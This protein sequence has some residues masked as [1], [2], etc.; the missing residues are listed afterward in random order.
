MKNAARVFVTS[1]L[2]T[3]AISCGDIGIAPQLGEMSGELVTPVVKEPYDWGTADFIVALKD[4]PETV[5]F[6]DDEMDPAYKNKDKMSAFPIRGIGYN[7][8]A[9][10]IKQIVIIM[11]GLHTVYEGEDSSYLGYDY[12][13]AHLAEQG[14]TVISIDGEYLNGNVP[15]NN[16]VRGFLILNHLNQLL[17]RYG[18]QID[19]NNLGDLKIAIIGHSR[20]G[21]GANAAWM[22]KKYLLDYFQGRGLLNNPPENFGINLK[23]VRI[24]SIVGIAPVAGAIKDK[25]F[26]NGVVAGTNFQFTDDKLYFDNVDYFT[27][28][29]SH[30]GDTYE[31]LG[32]RTYDNAFKS[33]NFINASGEKAALFIY[34]GNHSYFNSN[35]AKH[36]NN[37]PD[38]QKHGINEKRVKGNNVKDT[39]GSV[40]PGD[41]YIA[42]WSPDKNYRAIVQQEIAREYIETFLKWSFNKNDNNLRKILARHENARPVFVSTSTYPNLAQDCK[43]VVTWHQ[44]QPASRLF[45]NNYEEDDTK[46]TCSIMNPGVPGSFYATN[47]VSP[48]S[49]FFSLSEGKLRN[50]YEEYG[51][52]EPG[53][54][55]VTT[56]QWSLNQKKKYTYTV[57]LGLVP[58]AS[59]G[60]FN[61]LAFRAGQSVNSTLNNYGSS[62]TI[63]VAVN[64]AKLVAA[65]T[66]RDPMKVTL[67]DYLLFGVSKTMMETYNIP[68]TDFSPGL[69]S[70]DQVIKIEFI[71]DDPSNS[72]RIILDDIQFTDVLD[73]LPGTN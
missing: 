44:Y 66:L 24:S 8:D 65:V 48:S 19:G 41:G 6:K 49:L 56:L 21:E 11:H 31:F 17:K 37:L 35:W 71:L 72:G 23:N 58:A 67:Y 3:L 5:Q 4:F 2:C 32:M 51:A 61:A 45:I 13:A 46:T 50:D 27:L 53:E 47:S 68:L 63:N 7:L 40:V 54:S 57:D 55:E 73:V 10:P 59:K 38:S 64:G 33:E 60:K 12:L 1:L 34:G 43:R 39:N 14:M 16:V 36:W 62:K 22:L 26:K 20:G 9:N 70:S 15:D 29:G 30:D 42:E 69:K 52:I 28:Q 18:A 25:E